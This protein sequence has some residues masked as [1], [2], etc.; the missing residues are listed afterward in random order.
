MRVRGSSRVTSLDCARGVKQTAAHTARGGPSPSLFRSDA[1]RNAR[2]IR[3]QRPL[4]S[5]SFRPHASNTRAPPL[6]SYRRS[7]GAVSRWRFRAQDNQY[8]GAGKFHPRAPMS[9]NT[10][11]EAVDLLGR[12]LRNA[13]FS[14]STASLGDDTMLRLLRSGGFNVRSGALVL[15]A[16]NRYKAFRLYLCLKNGPAALEPSAAG[17]SGARIAAAFAGARIRPTRTR[18]EACARA[19]RPAMR[20]R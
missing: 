9:V 12:A 11:T 14:E 7:R 13:D 10:H 6:R 19:A 1:A 8:P 20:P 17:R 2:G 4:G 18:S 16:A 15:P 3:P 5:G